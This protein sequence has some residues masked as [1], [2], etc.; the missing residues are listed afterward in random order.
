MRAIPIFIMIMLFLV[1]EASAQSASPAASM[2]QLHNPF[3][4]NKSYNAFR[5]ATSKDARPHVFDRKFLVL[6]GL[7]TTATVFDIRSTSHCLSAYSNCRE[8]NPL[9][10]SNPSRT[11]LYGISLSTVAGEIFASAWLR[12]RQ[13]HS[14]LWIVPPIALMTSRAIGAALNMARN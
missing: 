5:L 4:E 13:P 3:V 6:T 11:K 9:L 1:I 7:A 12:R 2:R 10:G 14:K 8:A